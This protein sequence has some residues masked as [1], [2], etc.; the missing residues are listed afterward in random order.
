MTRA[1]PSPV[2]RQSLIY[3]GGY[4]RSGSTLLGRLLADN[5]AVLDLGEVA[6]AGEF[7]PNPRWNCSCGRKWHDCAVWSRIP[8]A[9]LGNG[10]RDLDAHRA[11]IEKLAA[12][13][14]QYSVI[15]DG[16]K[17]AHRQVRTP[18]YLAR[19]STLPMTF[20][21]L[22]R[23]PRAVAWSRFRDRVR[24]KQSSPFWLRAAIAAKVAVAWS[25]ANLIAETFALRHRSTSL[26]VRYDRMLTEGVPEPLNRLIPPGPLT[27]RV[28]AADRG[29]T[30]SVSG[31]IRV[32]RSGE[33]TIKPDEDWR[34]SLNGFLSA[35]IVVLALPLMLRYGLLGRRAGAQMATMG[36]ARS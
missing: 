21:H 16:S 26:R 23:D 17:T 25:V 15:V 30:H 9:L 6:R 14:P 33:I 35:T 12:D 22:V 36:K 28:L 8:P 31:N 5:P 11:R 3:I 2:A 19:R 24:R 27:G 32:R 4:G 7:L 20:I 13:F 29:N 10:E 1:T 34:D 18:G